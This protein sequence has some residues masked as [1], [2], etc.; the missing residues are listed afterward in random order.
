M[1]ELSESPAKALI[2]VRGLGVCFRLLPS[3]R[4]SLKNLLLGGRWQKP[5]LLW[6]LRNVDLACYP[7]QTLGIVGPASKAMDHGH[8]VLKRH[9]N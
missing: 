3:K 5:P 1:S 9:A 6:A 2:E 8:T 7:G 4:A